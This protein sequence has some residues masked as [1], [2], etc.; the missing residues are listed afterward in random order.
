MMN[1]YA[2][3][4]SVTWISESNQPS[5]WHF[6]AANEHSVT[7]PRYLKYAGRSSAVAGSEHSGC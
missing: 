6:G 7:D 1:R 2:S 4:P 3:A 5:L